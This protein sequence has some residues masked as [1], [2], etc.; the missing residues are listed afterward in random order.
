MCLHGCLIKMKKE[1]EPGGRWKEAKKDEEERKGKQKEAST[2]QMIRSQ[3]SEVRFNDSHVTGFELGC[4][5]LKVQ[6]WL[7]WFLGMF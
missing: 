7:P 5:L 3:P 2:V 4:R 1:E 6:N